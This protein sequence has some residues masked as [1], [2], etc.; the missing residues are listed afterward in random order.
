MNKYIEV[1]GAGV[2]VCD[3]QCDA[4]WVRFALE[5]VEYLIFFLF[6]DKTKRGI[7]PALN[8]QYLRNSAEW[9]L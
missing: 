4:L 6:G 1:S 7:V 2:R 9:F 5:D 3:C 8:M